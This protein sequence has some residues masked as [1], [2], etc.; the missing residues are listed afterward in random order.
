MTLRT[1]NQGTSPEI[2]LASRTRSSVE[3]FYSFTDDCKGRMRHLLGHRSVR[4]A[5]R[6]KFDMEA[7]T[8]GAC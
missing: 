7:I 2:V 8:V 6:A 4:L 3:L 5:S 1:R